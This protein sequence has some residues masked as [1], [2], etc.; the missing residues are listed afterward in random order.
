MI[1]G[2]LRGREL[3]HQG[4]TRLDITPSMHARK[5][6]MVELSDAFVALPGGF[7]TFD[8]LFEVMTWAQLGIH[9]QPIGVLDVDGYFAP[10][11]AIMDRAIA[12]GF[13][14]DDFRS[15]VI[16]ETSV[17]KL[18]DRLAAHRPPSVRKWAD[19]PES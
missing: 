5:A 10:F 16:R 2:A 11:A 1:P 3:A 18:L 13:V 7:G 12:E 9:D 14:K 4:L 19:L 6:R 8:E 15:L 17:D